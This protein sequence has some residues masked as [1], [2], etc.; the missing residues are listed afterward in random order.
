VADRVALD[1]AAEMIL[2]AERPLIML[3]ATA[4]R[5]RLTEALS[6]FVRRVQIPFFN[7]QMGKGSVA[8][9]SGLYMGTAALF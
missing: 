5:P 3:G 1:R 6:G 2:E 4:S 7:T 8:G 9:G